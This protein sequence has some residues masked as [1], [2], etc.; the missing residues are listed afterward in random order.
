MWSMCTGTEK[1]E[2]N[3]FEEVSHLL[4]VTNQIC[5]YIEWMQ[6]FVW[7]T[8]PEPNH[9]TRGIIIVVLS[10]VATVRARFH[11]HSARTHT[12]TPARWFSRASQRIVF[13]MNDDDRYGSFEI[14]N[15]I[16]KFDHIISRIGTYYRLLRS[17]TG[18]CCFFFLARSLRDC[19]TK[20]LC[21]T[22]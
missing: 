10:S 1:K 8:W 9:N 3:R 6:T 14:G 15:K 19:H 12:Q 4:V 11:F 17:Q 5:L 18:N 22:K 16:A 7:S 13:R 20:E 21:I 2:I